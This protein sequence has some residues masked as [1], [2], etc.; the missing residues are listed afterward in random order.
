MNNLF[1]TIYHFWN[2]DKDLPGAKSYN[3]IMD[4]VFGLVLPFIVAIAGIF[5]LYKIT[6]HAFILNK[7]TDPAQKKKSVNAIITAVVSVVLIISAETIVPLVIKISQHAKKI[8]QQGLEAETTTAFVVP[9]TN[10]TQ[11]STTAI[12]TKNHTFLLA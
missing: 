4:L 2:I 11:L 9:Q 5:L 8:A 6:Q 10:G 12:K 3:T 1:L 7:T